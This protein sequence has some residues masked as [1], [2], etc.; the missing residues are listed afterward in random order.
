MGGDGGVIAVNRSFLRQCGDGFLNEADR[1]GVDER[2]RKQLRTK[3][4]AVSNE[5]LKEPIVACELGYLY[6]KDALL[7]ALLNKTLNPTFSHVRGMKDIIETKFTKNT[8]AREQGEDTTQFMCPVTMIEFTGRYSFS[9]IRKTGWVLSDKAINEV[10]IESLQVEYGPFSSDDIIRLAPDSEQ[11]NAM[12][13]KLV[14]DRERMKGE[15]SKNKK[16]TSD[17]IQNPTKKSKKEKRRMKSKEAVKQGKREAGLVGQ[18]E[19]SVKKQIASSEV[20][21]SLFGKH[22]PTAAELF[23]QGKASCPI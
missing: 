22:N 15:R 9:V 6:N 14:S 5:A 17:A 19:D 23:T 7:T 11:L 20:F 21:K 10:G 13:E 1:G 12:R 3:V 8:E 4:C 2:E 18:A 16:R